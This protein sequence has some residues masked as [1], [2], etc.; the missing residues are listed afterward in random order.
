LK[1][2]IEFVEWRRHHQ[3]V[4]ILLPPSTEAAV[5]KDSAPRQ[6]NAE[7]P[8]PFYQTTRVSLPHDSLPDGLIPCQ[9]WTVVT[10]STPRGGLEHNYWCLT[11]LLHPCVTG[12]KIHER[13]HGSSLSLI[14]TAAQ[15]AVPSWLSLRTMRPQE[16]NSG[17]GSQQFRKYYAAL[18][19]MPH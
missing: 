9:L 3:I 2:T 1:R 6:S 12:S 16:S 17:S 5:P 18:T 10:R 14:I 4:T 15:H 11:T 7:K 13:F 19:R 8:P